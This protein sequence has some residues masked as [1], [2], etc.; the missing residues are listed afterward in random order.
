MIQWYPGLTCQWSWERGWGR[1]R[2]GGAGSGSPEYRNYSSSSH[3]VATH[4][5]QTLAWQHEE[6]AR[7]RGSK[8]RWEKRWSA[9]IMTTLC[10]HTHHLFSQ[11]HSQASVRVPSPFPLLHSALMSFYTLSPSLFLFLRCVMVGMSSF[12]GESAFLFAPAM[13]LFSLML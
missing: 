5:A 2:G 6:R 11:Y 8:G 10:F 1:W 13:P 7:K 3:S 4:Y 9:P 12:Q